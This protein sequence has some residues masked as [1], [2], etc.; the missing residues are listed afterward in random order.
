[1]D[2]T[3]KI[4]WIIDEYGHCVKRL[5]HFLKINRVKQAAQQMAQLQ[6][7]N[8]LVLSYS[9]QLIFSNRLQQSGISYIN[10]CL[11]K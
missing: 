9:S 2:D 4:G 6:G 5:K 3:W 8:Q 1:M 10:L 11:T 7:V